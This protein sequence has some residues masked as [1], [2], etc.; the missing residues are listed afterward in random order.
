MEYNGYLMAGHQGHK[1]ATQFICVDDRAES[2]NAGHVSKG[3]K[4]L[5]S[6]E[7]YCG[8]LQCPPYVAGRELTCVVCSKK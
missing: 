7:G 8:A 5:Y 4:L 1:S 3:G 2:L 6:V